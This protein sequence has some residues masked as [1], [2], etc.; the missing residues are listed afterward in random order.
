MRYRAAWAIVAASTVLLA[1]CAP[2]AE[3]AGPTDAEVSAYIADQNA[4]WWHSIAPD[5]PP[6]A[7]PVVRTVKAQEQPNLIAECLNANG[8]QYGFSSQA[9][10]SDSPLLRAQWICTQQFPVAPDDEVRKNVLGAA[11]L[12]Y[13]YDYFN[14]RVIPCLALNGYS[15]G[16]VP[17]RAAF[18]RDSIGQPAWNPY[19][20]LEPSP[21]DADG[22]KIIAARCPPPPFASSL[23]PNQDR[24]TPVG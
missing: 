3:L 4:R 1:G 12:A 24:L 9:Q 20:V 7:V 13:L 6:P 8:F 22:V 23:V 21:A 10:G 14:H 19:L 18:L 17:S 11:Q 2:A 16:E 5:E 15:V